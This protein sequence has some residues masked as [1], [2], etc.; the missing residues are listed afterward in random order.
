[1]VM[2]EIGIMVPMKETMVNLE[3]AMEEMLMS[4]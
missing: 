4:K 2:V 3:P 1:M